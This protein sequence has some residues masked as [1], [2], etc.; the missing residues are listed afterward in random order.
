MKRTYIAFVL[1]E[2]GSMQQDIGVTIAGFNA[3]V[4]IVQENNEL[5]GDTKVSLITFGGAKALP[6]GKAAAGLQIGGTPSMASAFIL[7]GATLLNAGVQGLNTAGVCKQ[8]INQDPDRL[9]KLTSDTYKPNGGT[10]L[11]DAI[12]ETIDELL[13][14]KG[15]KSKDTAFLVAIFTD[16][17][18]NMSSK[19]T[20]SQ[21]SDKIK[22]LEKTGR[23]TFTLIGPK[24]EI[25]T[26]GDLLSI[27]KGNRSEF[28][29]TLTVSKMDA[30][31]NLSGA[32]ESY[33][34]MRSKN[35]M[36]SACL[37]SNE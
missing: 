11:Y 10:P 1:D 12:G 18:E 34:I 8:F 32:T 7:G 31:S 33:M 36:E 35:I 5:G 15:A 17:Y 16:G 19:Y 30:F 26:M 24:G 4:D 9:V 23:W 2:S 37:Y 6:L 3:Q 28:D 13:K 27:R 29:P 25:E 22:E 20:S 14:S 21:I